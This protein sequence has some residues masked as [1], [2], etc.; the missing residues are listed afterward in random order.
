MYY[1]EIKQ[2]AVVQFSEG[3]TGHILACR[4]RHRFGNTLGID[5]SKHGKLI[6]GS[7]IHIMD[8]VRDEDVVMHGDD[9]AYPNDL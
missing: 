3:G 4:I 2:G 1:P 8:I 5:Y 6:R 7:V 9:L